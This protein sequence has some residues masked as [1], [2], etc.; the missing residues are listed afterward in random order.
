[1][2]PEQP[3]Y[4]IIVP[5][6]NERER[7]G[8]SLQTIVD[9]ARQQGWSAEIVAVDDGSSDETAEII[10][11]LAAQY[12][13]IR[14]VRNPGNR[15][16]GY[17]VR[18]GMLNARGEIL[19]F[20]DADLSSPISEAPKLFSAIARGAEVA[21][22]S[23]WLDPSL[24]FERQPLKR[25]IFSRIFNLFLRV[26]LGLNFRDTQCGFKA[27]TRRASTLIF[28]LQRIDR[29]GFDAEILYIARKKGLRV[30]EVPV[31]WGH[32]DRSRLSPLKDGMRMGVEA[33][34]VRWNSLAGRYQA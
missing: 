17:A 20:T 3:K 34:K 25:Q 6:Y 23:R 7:L 10:N 33:L 8:R 30:T 13:E 12:P 32:D 19:L 11:G 4:S 18:N 24:Q 1:M 22:G 27:F 2:N 14:L 28:P 16:K 26:L 15:G 31:A 5:A 9:Y 29:W 21:I